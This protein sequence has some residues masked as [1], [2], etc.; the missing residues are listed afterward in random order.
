M[1]LVRI[2]T[3]VDAMPF[4]FFPSKTLNPY[5]LEWALSAYAA[6]LARDSLAA[7]DSMRAEIRLDSLLKAAG[8]VMAMDP[9]GNRDT[10]VVHADG[11]TYSWTCLK[12]TDAVGNIGWV[13]VLV[14]ATPLRP[15][16]I[17]AVDSEN[18]PCRPGDAYSV[19][20]SFRPWR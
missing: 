6:E 19:L 12:W 5:Q 2:G 3:V 17:Y 7:P 9:R 15:T 13:A 10:V 14:Q 4:C 8:L 20:Q 11:A 16:M 18:C 1:W